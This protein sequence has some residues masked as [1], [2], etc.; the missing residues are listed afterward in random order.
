MKLF[1]QPRVTCRTA[2]DAHSISPSGGFTLLELLAVIL[3][4]GMLSASLLP[5]V[6]RTR[7]PTAR[8]KCLDNIRKLME[9]TGMFAL[10]NGDAMPYPNWGTSY[11]GWLFSPLGGRPPPPSDTGYQSG[12]LWQFTKTAD[13]YRC[14][15]DFTSRYYSQ[16]ANQLSTYVMNGAVCGYGTLANTGY[17]LSQ[18]RGEAWCLWEPD[19]TIGGI[20]AF[21]YSDASAYPDRNEGPG[22]THPLGTPVGTFDGAAIF[23]SIRYF[24]AQQTA[25]GS[26]LVWCNPAT[27]NGR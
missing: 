14:P 5:A 4:L 6:A 25:P 3:V 10:D 21:A 19:E 1:R 27:P 9:A 22:R 13:V 18:F 12:K 20:G 2:T 26:S 17:R 23:P 8:T 11:H 24:Q 7:I 15:L 16:R